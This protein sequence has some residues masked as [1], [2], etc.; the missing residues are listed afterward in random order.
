MNKKNLF[1]FTLLLFGQIHYAC[2][3]NQAYEKLK[4]DTKLLM[5]QAVADTPP[6][7]SSFDSPQ[8]ESEWLFKMDKRLQLYINDKD[9]REILLKSIHYE[10]T[11]AG[12]DPLLILG[13][14]QV[15]SK[16]KKYAISSVGARGYMQVMPFWKDEIGNDSQNLFYMRTNLRYGC[17]ILRHYLDVEQGNLFMALG[18]YNGSRG[19]AKYPNAVLGAMAQ[20]QKEK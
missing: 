7:V 17:V 14:I 20:F 2:A 16:F 15:E 10:A 3:G 13:L 12:L 5:T 8:Q 11:R 19:Q 4:D 18:R 1:F 9:E 6:D